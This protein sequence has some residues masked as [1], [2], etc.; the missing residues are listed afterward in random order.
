LEVLLFLLSPSYFL[1]PKKPRAFLRKVESIRLINYIEIAYRLITVIAMMI[2]Y[3]DYS[4]LP[5][6]FEGL[7]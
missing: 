6:A 2:L 7:G 3:A 1:T 4:R 5:I